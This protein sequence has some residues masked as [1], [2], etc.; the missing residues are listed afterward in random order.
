M[1]EA[2]TVNLGSPDEDEYT[3]ESGFDDS[4]EA[5]GREAQPD[6]GRASPAENVQFD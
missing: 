4:R 2:E 5:E 3:S 6:P 1:S